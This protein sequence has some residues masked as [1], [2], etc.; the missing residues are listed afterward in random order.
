MGRAVPR[1]PLREGSGVG[2]QRSS[3][4]ATTPHFDS[5][6]TRRAAGHRTLSL[7]HLEAMTVRT[8]NGVPHRP[9]ADGPD[10]FTAFYRAHAEALLV[11]FVRRT[12]DVEVARDLTAETFARAFEH[13]RRFRGHTEGEAAGWLFG[14]ARH[15][16]SRY[17]RRGSAECRAATR[18]G[19]SLPPV[20][21]DD[22]ARV[23]DLAGVEQLRLHVASA[24]AALSNDHQRAVWLR[25]VDELTYTQIA[26]QLDVTEG[27]A[28]A[29]VSRGLRALADATDLNV[30]KGATT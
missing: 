14:I 10:A 21:D 25:V 28:R 16:L 6:R 5:P 22:V 13:R 23:L 26:E 27:T 20:G 18:L 19:I 1:A 12:F 3:G 2:A 8:P 30:L 9:F 24:F 4:S 29:R 17:V 7:W 11:F 15:Q